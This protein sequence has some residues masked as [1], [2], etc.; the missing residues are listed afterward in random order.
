MQGYLNRPDATAETIR[1]D[2]FLRTGDLA[3]LDTDGNI[4][5]Q[6][7]LKELIKVKGMQVAPAEVEGALLELVEVA[8]A[9][10]IGVDDERAGQLPKAFVVLKPGA[11]LSADGV[12]EGLAAK[13]SAFKLPQQVEFVESIPKSASGKLL[14]R[15]LK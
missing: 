1:P 6:D 12:R 14:R 7:R 11:T 10:V 9:A 2:G 5:F 3:R 8:D 13:L 15:L 4:F